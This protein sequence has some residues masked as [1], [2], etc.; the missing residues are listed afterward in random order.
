MRKVVRLVMGLRVRFH[1]FH[2]LFR[3][4]LRH[5]RPLERRFLRLAHRVH[6]VAFVPLPCHRHSTRQS[7]V[8]HESYSR[9]PGCYRTS[10]RLR[11]SF[12]RSTGSTGCTYA[13]ASPAWSVTP[14][15][16]TA[17][18]TPAP[19]TAASRRRCPRTSP[20]QRRRRVPWHVKRSPR[21]RS[22]R[23]SPL[24]KSSFGCPIAEDAKI[25][26]RSLSFAPP[27]M[28]APARRARLSVG[29]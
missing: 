10:R 9:R 18:R 13:P 25:P 16:R 4:K 20:A 17:A 22:N 12:Y 5:E 14:R 7:K 21:R 6:R 11:R 3:A 15:T 23:R 1:R 27:V 28:K 8:I 2:R 29:A 19:R 26:P 24:P